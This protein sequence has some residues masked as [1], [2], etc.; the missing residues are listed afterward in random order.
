MAAT[1][2]GRGYWEVASDG[3]IFAFG[4]A[5]FEG[6]MGGQSLNAPVVGM[7]ATPD[8]KG[9]WEVASDG[10]IFAFGDAVFE[11]SMGGQPLAAPMV[12]M[13]ATPDGNGY[14]EVASDGG[15]FAFGD[16]A[17][18][19]SEGGHHL[20]APLVGMAITPH[21][22]G[23]WEVA[24]DG[25]SFPFGDAG[26]VG[27][28]PS[29]PPRVAFYGDS[30]GMQAGQEFSGPRAGGRRF[31]VLS[32]IPRHRRLR[33]APEHAGGR[34]RL[35]PHR[36]GHR[37]RR[38]RLHAVHGGR[39]DRISSVLRG[40]SEPTRKPQST[41]FARDGAEVYLVG[42]P[43]DEAASLNLNIAALNQLYASLAAV[44]TGVDY[45]DAGQ[46]VMAYG[47][48]TWTLPC[49]PGEPCTGPSGT[50]VVRSPDGVHFCPSATVTVVDY[51]AECSVYSSG[52]FRFASA[53]LSPVLRG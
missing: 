48:F 43:Y 17:F 19:G 2:D 7:A 3:G 14:W 34:R 39:P 46:A 37:I 28:P 36:G 5:A 9:Y 16:A 29:V 52:A 12:G 32:G 24:S 15:V 42:L 40:V 6:S 18:E 50:N 31:G 41:C 20:D 10:G 23:Y 45:V 1:P 30:L 51:F 35:P 13:A 47:A 27:P 4:N 8:G 33:L 25:D 38:Q 53:M 26:P 44:N 11:G 49:L 22:K 21:G